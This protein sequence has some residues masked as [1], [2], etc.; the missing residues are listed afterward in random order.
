M[1]HAGFSVFVRIIRMLKTPAS[2]DFF[3]FLSRPDIRSSRRTPNLVQNRSG[4]HYKAAR[5]V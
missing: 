3:P 5:E 2:R 1:L 4:S